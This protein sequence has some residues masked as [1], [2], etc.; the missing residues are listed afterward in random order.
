MFKTNHWTVLGLVFIA[1]LLA[2]YYDQMHASMA[3]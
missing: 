2:G 3:N 1:Y